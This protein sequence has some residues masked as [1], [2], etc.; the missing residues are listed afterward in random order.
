MDS[1]DRIKIRRGSD[2]DVPFI[3]STWLK[4][5]YYGNT[6][7]RQIPSD[8][9]YPNYHPV[10]ER[11]LERSQVIVACLASNEDVIIGYAVVSEDGQTL[12]WT[13]VKEAWRQFGLCKRMLSPLSIN[14][15][16]HITNIGKRIKPEA[17]VFNPF[18]L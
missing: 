11:L 5:L 12:H 7:W 3:F 10:V 13:H 14:Q 15:V 8:I 6:W 4:G 16:S 9:Y 2:D 1:A 17:W 18:S